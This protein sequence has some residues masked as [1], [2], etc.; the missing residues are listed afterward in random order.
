MSSLVALVSP[1]HQVTD[2]EVSSANV[3]VVV[4]PE[5]LLI[6]CGVQ[7]SYIAS[8]LELVEGV[9]SC[10]IVALLVVG[11]QPRGPIL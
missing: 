11:F 8:L 6:P 5:I 4:A 7:Y 9:F 10:G 2:M 3:F 1:K